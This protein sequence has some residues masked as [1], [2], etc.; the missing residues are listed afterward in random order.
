MPPRCAACPADM[1][2]DH[3][4]RLAQ[5]VIAENFFLCLLRQEGKGGGKFRMVQNGGLAAGGKKIFFK[6]L[7]LGKLDKLLIHQIVKGN[8]PFPPPAQLQNYIYGGVTNDNLAKGVKGVEISKVQPNSMAAQRGLKSGDIIIGI[9]RQSIESTQDLRKALDEKPS[10]VALNILRGKN[11]F[12]LL[13][14]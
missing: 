3:S 2:A 5:E 10:A 9:N 13:V 6:L 14:Q 11:N 8:F 7:R 1:Y 12:Y 4:L